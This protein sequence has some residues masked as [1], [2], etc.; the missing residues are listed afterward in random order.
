M[1]P[2]DAPLGPR[3]TPA[4]NLSIFAQRARHLAAISGVATT[5]PR[6]SFKGT[7]FGR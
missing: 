5:S 4:M 3:S 1:V 7:V 6:S 2:I